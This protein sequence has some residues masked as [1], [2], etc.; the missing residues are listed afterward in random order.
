M[1]L[2]QEAL[3]A[4]NK[5]EEAKT[6]PRRSLP[7]CA[8]DHAVENF[9]YTDESLLAQHQLN[10]PLLPYSAWISFLRRQTEKNVPSLQLQQLT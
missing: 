10:T 5:T 8:Y 1:V 4:A 6:F 2:E 7:C 9:A 3:R